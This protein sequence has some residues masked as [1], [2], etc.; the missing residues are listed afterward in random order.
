M[1]LIKRFILFTISVSLCVSAE[2]NG[3]F[4]KDFLFGAASSSYQVE[5][6]WNEDGK[7]ENIWDR[8][9]HAHPE[10][11]MNRDNGDVACDSYHKYKEDVSIAADLGLKHYRFSISWT[12]IL[13]SGYDN[14]VNQKGILYYQNLIEEILKHKMIPVATI[15]HWDLPQ[16]LQDIGGWTNPLLVNHFVNYARIVIKNFKDVGYWITINE[17]KQVCVRGYGAGDFAPGIKGSGIANYLCAYLIA[18]CHAATYH[19]YKD[20]FPHYKAKMSITL[21]GEWSE[22]ASNKKKDVEAAERRNQFEFGLYANPILNGDW[23]EVV[24]DRIAERSALE[25]YSESR[26]PIFTR[27]EIDYINGTFDFLGF[28]T[29]WTLLVA[30]AKEA[31]IKSSSYKNDVRAVITKDPKWK[32]GSNGNTIVP[33]GVRKMLQ[34]IQKTYNNPD[35]FITECGVSDDG[36]SLDDDDRISFYTDYLDAILDAMYIDGMRIFGFT[37]WSLMDNFEWTGGYSYHFGLYH[38]NFSDPQRTR[39]PKKS[40]IFF[41]ELA[42]THRIPQV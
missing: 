28:N 32:L 15:Y 31:S 2:N 8:M 10:S 26:L 21:D 18:K 5:G 27:E 33:W 25:N 1:V 4:P 35:I 36:T 41:R 13:P 7:G 40:T 11:I 19:M 22:P 30:D 23:P 34:W 12:R 17:P 39:T 37:A 29:Y 14:Y 42:K 3:T 9:T 6:A 38:V 24:I 20:E 16:S